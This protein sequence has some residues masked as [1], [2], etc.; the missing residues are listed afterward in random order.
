MVHLPQNGIIGF[1]PWP[2]W[3]RPRSPASR[4]QCR[5]LLLE[6]P[7]P[8][9]QLAA[10][11]RQALGEVQASNGALGAGVPWTPGV[12]CH[13]EPPPKKKEEYIFKEGGCKIDPECPPYGGGGGFG[14]AALLGVLWHGPP[15][16]L[17]FL[18]VALKASFFFFFYV[19]GGGVEG[20]VT[21]VCCL[22]L[23][24]WVGG[25]KEHNRSL[26]WFPF[27]VLRG[28]GRGG[29]VTYWKS[30]LPWVVTES[31]S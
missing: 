9:A 29:G 31:L 16:V 15:F 20:F 24:V 6:A 13:Q 4:L 23:F 14:R 10:L 28:E 17:L 25:G 1:D 19:G 12:Y 8:A 22:F 30:S 26:R 21:C 3:L 5:A 18:S 7:L 27:F 2:N 11:L